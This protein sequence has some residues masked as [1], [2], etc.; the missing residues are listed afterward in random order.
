VCLAACALLFFGGL[1]FV[2]AVRAPTAKHLSIAETGC[3]GHQELCDRRIDEV[4]FAGTHN[5]MSASN[6]DFIGANQVGGI[7]TQLAR[8]VR[9][10]AL[11]L[12]YGFRVDQ[13]VRTDVS[14]APG[15]SEPLTP[16]QQAAVDRVLSIAGM[17]SQ[18]S[19]PYLCHNVC[20]PGA[21]KA[22]TGFA[23]IHDFLR[24]N[25]NEVVLL[26]LQDEIEAADAVDVLKKSRLAD[27][28]YTWKPDSPFPTL[29]QMITARKNV[30]IMAEHGGGAADWYH[31]AYGPGGL[32][33]ETQYDF[34]SIEAMSCDPNRSGTAGRLFLLNH[35]VS[36]SPP[37][38]L[39]AARANSR[40]TLLGRAQR[41]EEVRGKRA[42]II[43]VDFH[44]RGD[45][46][47]VVDT[48]NKVRGDTSPFQAGPEPPAT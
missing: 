4:V 16:E 26:I 48:L 46:F 38:P 47:K 8:G 32:L 31:A 24:E 19:E 1:A 30:L 21:L 20:E 22:E 28:A 43:L 10:M 18:D 11:D 25:P 12:H 45:L 13:W 39:M 9:A 37:S 7:R 3:N 14:R 35:W 5:S 2:R 36:T 29:R 42:N 17:G 44:D 15:T 41:C 40:S 34:D 27:L 33:Q 6:E 23:R